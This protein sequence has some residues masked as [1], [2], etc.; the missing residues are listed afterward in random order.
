VII[1]AKGKGTM[2]CWWVNQVASCPDLR[3]KSKCEHDGE[4]GTA[5]DRDCGGEEQKS[6]ER[7]A[8]AL[9]GS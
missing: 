1:Q 7:Q 4:I 6:T 8:I 9:S 2:Q 5:V 3:E